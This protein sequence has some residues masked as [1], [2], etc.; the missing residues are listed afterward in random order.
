MHRLL[1]LLVIL[2]GGTLLTLSLHT[3]PIGY[4]HS[5]NQ[6]TTL[7]HIAAIS[8]DPT[9]WNAPY[10]TVARLPAEARQLEVK[11]PYSDFRIFEEFPLYHFLA[12][13][14]AQLGVSA[15][16]SGRIVSLVFWAVG[17]CGVCAL[18]RLFSPP[19]VA[20]LALLLYCCSFPV[21][22]YGV[23]IMSDTAMVALWSWSLF[24]LARSRALLTGTSIIAGLMCALLSGLFKSYG[25][26]ALIPW[27]LTIVSAVRSSTTGAGHDTPQRYIW[28]TGIG[29]IVAA[30]PTL[31]WHMYAGLHSGHQEFESHSVTQKL[32]MITS[33]SFW[34]ALQKGYFRY[35][36]Y[37]PGVVALV[38]GFFWIRAHRYREIPMA[39]WYAA[40][41]GVVFI[42]LTGD[43]IPHHDYY[44][45][46]PAVPL[47]VVVA[48]ITNFT[49]ERLSYRVRGL[50]LVGLFASIA[51]PSFLNV[52]KALAENRDVITCAEFVATLTQPD[53]LIGVYSDSSRYNSITYYAQRFGVRV[54]GTTLPLGRFSRV[55]VRQIVVNLSPIEFDRFHQWATRQSATAQLHRIEAR[56][57]KGQPRVCGVYPLPL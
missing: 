11:K 6:I 56:D 23:A 17:G 49:V 33:G 18:G 45:L 16:D 42:A 7:T 37:G 53:E 9:T 44:L 25:L 34:N 12:A 8:E 50:A 20:A 31:A 1:L 30:A 39:L 38:A 13:A 47:V 28:S 57:Y 2:V 21:A 15:E 40:I 29:I 27:G 55:G 22:Y 4:L 5:W 51:A 48:H 24:F 26:I 3:R 14:V 52:H 35:L 46:M 41:A 43:K 19:L 54:E 10:D 36:S 32:S